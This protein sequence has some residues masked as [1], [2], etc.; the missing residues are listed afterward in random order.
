ME[1][2]VVV[3]AAALAT[4]GLERLTTVT[5]ASASLLALNSIAFDDAGTM[6]VASQHDSL[7]LG[8]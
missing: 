4:V 2:L 5:T 8:S 6:W 1:V 3:A 7:L